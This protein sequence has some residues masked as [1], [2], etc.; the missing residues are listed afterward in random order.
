MANFDEAYARLNGEQRQA[1]DTIAGPVMVVAGPG[2]GKTEVLTLRIANIL[3]TTKT[4]PE[5]ILALTFTESGAVTMRRRLAELVGR[6]AYRVAISTFHGFANGIISDYPDYF[7][8]IAHGVPVAEIDQVRVMEKVI[9]EL[10]SDS[11]R[12]FGDRYHYLKSILRAVGELK[13]QGVSPE[14]FVVLAEDERRHFSEIPDLVNDSGKYEGKMKTKYLPM[15]RRIAR[16]MELALAYAAYEKKMR[17]ERQYD[18][19]DM[20]MAVLAALDANE[21]M[22]RIVQDAYD[23]FLVDEHQD[24]NNAQNAIIQKIAGARENPNLFAVGD[25]KQAIYRFQG[26]SL[27]NFRYFE[28]QYPRGVVIALT[29]NYRS[30]QAILDAAHV[31]SPRE[32]RLMARGGREE[33]CAQFVE[34]SSPDAECFFVALKIKELIEKKRVKPEE[35]AVLYR[36]NRDAEPFVRALEYGQ[37]PFVVE[38]DRDA[39]GDEDIR[40]L[41]LLLHAVEHFGREPELA[42]I[43]HVDFLNIPPLDAYKLFAFARRERKSLY[44]IMRSRVLIEKSGA[45]N[46][47]AAAALSDNLSKWKRDAENS[48]AATAFENIVRESGFLASVLRDPAAMEKLAK[49]HAIF[50]ILKS[51]IERQKNYTL[52][53]FFDYL[54]LMERHG[55]AVKSSPAKGTLGRVRLMTAHRA[56]GQ[57]F[58]AVFIV[59]AVAK[60]WGDRFHRDEIRLPVS[61]YKSD[62]ADSGSDDEEA[63]DDADERNVFYVALTRAKRELWITASRID[64][65]G[66]EQLPTKFVSDLGIDVLARPV[67]EAFEESFV[68]HRD[69]EFAPP[70]EKKPELHDKEFLNALFEEQGLSPTALN[71]Y[72]AC[73]WQYFYRNLIRIPE[74]PNKNLSF[75]TAIHAALRAYFDALDAGEDKGKEYMIMR[76]E[77]ALS[78]EPITEDEYDEA[79]MKGK[80]ALAAYYDEHH[81]TWGASKGK[82]EVKIDGVETD[83]VKLNG[84]LDRII[85]GPDPDAVKVFDYKTGHSKTRNELE[86]GTKNADGNYKRQ[87]TFYK[88]LLE[89]QG[90]YEMTEGIIDFIEPD[91]RGK[92]H[93]E[94]FDISS[95]ETKVLEAQIGEVAKEI[96]DLAFWNKIPHDKDCVYCALRKLME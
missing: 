46:I 40:K 3:R 71:N 50:D 86:G 5:R 4:P 10:P 57:E 9:D 79:L 95:G 56:K 66:R 8:E 30:T 29:G 58:E 76:F 83:G 90:I 78:H 81:G 55:V 21:D 15:E 51:F 84:K 93:R 49:L 32:K 38:S 16:N 74:A 45:E 61:I 17:A 54:D 42:A 37:I 64:R 20:I 68:S 23:Y 14:R 67:T 26:A 31:V 11:L 39:L 24:T 85:F 28:K 80:K 36:D 13:K 75:G 12:P 53:E 33:K 65:D 6:D 43:L 91:V 77:E 2:T 70:P 18:Y 47:D 63:E 59:N 22:R 25:E 27:E 1:V 89:K 60:K 48:G 34:L 92:F 7:P 19:D 69:L 82:N 94:A 88:L 52:R 35:I 62:S 72:L 87:L 44:D 73:P 96:R 41:I